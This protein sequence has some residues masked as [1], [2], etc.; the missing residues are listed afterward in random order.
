MENLGQRWIYND[1]NPCDTAIMFASHAAPRLKLKKQVS[2][3]NAILAHIVDGRNSYILV[4]VHLPTSWASATQLADAI[5]E[6]HINAETLAT[7]TKCM[8]IIIGGDWNAGVWTPD[9]PAE[10]AVTKRAQ[11]LWEAS[12]SR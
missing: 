8:H 4:D 12:R 5:E 7:E 3:R 2:L 1:I 6:I 9:A 11:K 10:R